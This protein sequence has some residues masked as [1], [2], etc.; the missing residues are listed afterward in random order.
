MSRNIIFIA[1]FIFII[2]LSCNI[3]ND[4]YDSG[5]SNYTGINDPIFWKPDN[6]GDIRFYINDP[7]V[8]NPIKGATGWKPGEYTE[9]T[10]TYVEVDVSK[11]S[12]HQSMGY[13]IIFCIQDDTNPLDNTNDE[14][15][16]FLTVMINAEGK[17]CIGKVTDESSDL[18]P[19]FEYLVNWQENEALQTG[20]E[21]FNKI[22]ITYIG[23][24]NFEIIFNDTEEEKISF[25]YDQV[26]PF[27]IIGR[28][29]YIVTLAANEYFPDIPVDVRF[30][31]VYPVDI[32]LH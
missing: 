8:L 6:S 27:E 13:G 22:K 20:Y 15:Y 32:L 28:Y 5:T 3:K 25:E 17:Y 19:E 9:E 10:M 24:N 2:T 4:Y 26:S 31:Q 11:Y 7:S 21:K 29:G 30:S 14:G 18:D 23:E 12:G 1:I 16:N